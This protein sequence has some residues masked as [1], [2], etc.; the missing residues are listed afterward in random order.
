[1]KETVEVK[2]RRLK[3][4]H[5]DQCFTGNDAVDV[6]LDRLISQRINFS[7]EV[8]RDKAVKVCDNLLQ[9]Y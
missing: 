4:R 9:K 1:M 5:Y 6:V 7:K 3:M 2:R 8:S